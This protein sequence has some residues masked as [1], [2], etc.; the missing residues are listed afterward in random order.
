MPRLA[1]GEDDP[2]FLSGI[3]LG[4]DGRALG[5]DGERVVRQPIERVA[6]EQRRGGRGSA[7]GVAPRRSCTIT[8]SAA[9]S[10]APRASVTATIAGSI[11]GAMPTASATATAKSS[12]SS[13]GLSATTCSANTSSTSTPTTRVSSS[14][15]RRNPRSKSVSGARSTRRCAIAPSSVRAPVATTR[16]VAVPLRTLVPR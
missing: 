14:P 2:L 13:A 6:R 11:S 12:D 8:P 15:K 10:R 9:I 5:D 7:S 4:E 3:D 16:A 1:Q